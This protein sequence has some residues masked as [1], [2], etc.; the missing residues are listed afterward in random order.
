MRRVVNEHICGTNTIGTQI[1]EKTFA[2]GK[3]KSDAEATDSTVVK[4]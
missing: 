4:L 2:G 3:K 1:N